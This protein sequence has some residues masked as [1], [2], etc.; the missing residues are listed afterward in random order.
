MGS[1]SQKTHNN[2]F[3]EDY[4]EKLAKEMNQFNGVVK[5]DENEGETETSMSGATKKSGVTNT[6][7]QRKANDAAK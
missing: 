1:K 7:G 6:S 3:Y 4:K 2:K 5:L